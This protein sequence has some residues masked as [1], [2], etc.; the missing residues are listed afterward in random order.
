MDSLMVKRYVALV[1]IMQDFV[2]L[3]VA[4]GSVIFAG[5]HLSVQKIEAIMKGVM[6]VNDLINVI[7]PKNLKH[8]NN[9][10]SI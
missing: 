10:E 9:L 5:A 8:C 2:K 7:V 6:K 3:L 4:N 1:M